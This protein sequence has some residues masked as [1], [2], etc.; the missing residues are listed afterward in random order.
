MA[1]S[2]YTSCGL[3]IESKCTLLEKIQAMDALMDALYAQM[4]LMAENGTPIQ[5][6]MLNDGETIIRTNYNS[7]LSIQKTIDILERRKNTFVNQYNGRVTRGVDSKNFTGY[8][9]N[10]F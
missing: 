6:Y 7:Q 3:Y 9:N 8:P 5:E 1:A 4:L 10:N 2:I